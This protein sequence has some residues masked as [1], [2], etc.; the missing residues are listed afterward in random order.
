MVRSRISFNFGESGRAG[1][2][3]SVRA[4]GKATAGAT[5]VP[6]VR[7]FSHETANKKVTITAQTKMIPLPLTRIATLRRAK[8]LLR[9]TEKQN[10]ESR[11]QNP[12]E[13]KNRTKGAPGFHSGSWILDSALSPL[14]T[15]DVRTIRLTTGEE[16]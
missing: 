1:K 12:E 2:G 3:G 13:K 4:T 6:A 11:I 5:P 9:C 8:G 10:P 7:L 14:S 16:R 15:N